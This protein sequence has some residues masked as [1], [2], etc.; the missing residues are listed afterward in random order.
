MMHLL[1]PSTNAKPANRKRMKY[2]PLGTLGEFKTC[3]ED[4]MIHEVINSQQPQ[5]NPQQI[6]SMV[7]QNQVPD[8]MSQFTE[9]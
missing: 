3:K 1:K 7:D 6:N 2:N 9:S 5:M 4:T 8:E